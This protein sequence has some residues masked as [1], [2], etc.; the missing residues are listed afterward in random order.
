MS[1]VYKIEVEEI[2][3]NVYPVKAKSLAEAIDK[4]KEKYKN[5]DIVLYA[6]CLMETNFSEYKD[7]IVKGRCIER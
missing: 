7:D 5:G 6:E 1:K 2:L 4:V 3:Q